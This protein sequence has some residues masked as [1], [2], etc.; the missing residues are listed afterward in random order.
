MQQNLRN[1][2]FLQQLYDQPPVKRPLIGVPTGR[3]KSQ[4]FFGLPLY[5]MNQAYLRAIEQMGALPL[6]I[7]L[8][9]SAATLR[10]IFERLD[11]VLLPGGEDIDPAH[12]GEARDPMLGPT[13]RERD[14]TEM[15]LTRW[16]LENGMPIL[17]ICRGAQMINVVCGGSLY[18]DLTTQREDLDKHD[19][20]PPKYERFRISHQ[21]N[22]AE[23]SLLAAALGSTH[24]VN[25]MHHQ[26][27]K[28]LGNGLRGVATSED[29]LIEA[30][31]MPD[32][33]FAL[34]VQWHP[35][36]LTRTDALH[37]GLIYNFLLAAASDWRSQTPPGWAERFAQL[38][39]APAAPP[40]AQEAP[41][42]L[43]GTNGQAAPVDQPL[44]NAAGRVTAAL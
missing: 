1:Q 10:G 29:G 12:Y 7:P 19:Y 6:M 24:E 3:E 39:P 25:S 9:M 27:V 37:A 30:V 44:V 11:G 40:P 38:C 42:I 4:R 43:A 34:G 23:G 21:V 33:P 35:E 8:Q 31:E 16:A 17:G 2:D 14:R 32:L 41:A 36:E 22:V 13:D 15:L 18:Q 20:L 28:E 5:I 26:G